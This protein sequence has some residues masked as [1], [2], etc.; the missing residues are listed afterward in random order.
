MVGYFCYCPSPTLCLA[1]YDWAIDHYTFAGFCIGGADVGK[2]VCGECGICGVSEADKC[3][4]AVV[5]KSTMIL[6]L[7]TQTVNPI[8]TYRQNSQ[9]TH[10]KHQ[11]EAPGGIEFT[12]G[13]TIA[14]IQGR[15]DHQQQ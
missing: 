14:K 8:H 12:R 1:W 5:A 2:A 3:V 4:G 6:G 10:P 13:R 7:L 11:I 9:Y 15:I